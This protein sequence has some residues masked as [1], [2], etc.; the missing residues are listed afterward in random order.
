MA[1]ALNN[2]KRVDMPLNK[3]TK[4]NHQLPSW[5]LTYIA[6]ADIP[7]LVSDPGWTPHKNN[8]IIPHWTSGDIM[9]FQHGDVLKNLVRMVIMMTTIKI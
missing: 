8:E 1:L 5:H 9:P 7:Q 6:K 4:P 3:E 2:L